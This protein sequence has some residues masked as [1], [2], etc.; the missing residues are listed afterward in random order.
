VRGIAADTGVS[1]N[2]IT[3]YFGG[4]QGLFRAATENDF[5]IRPVLD[6]SLTGLGLRI[7]AHVVNRWEGKLGD[8]PLLTMMR[9]AL[10]DQTAAHHMAEFFVRQG[11]RPLANRLGPDGPERAAA[12]SVFIVGTLVQRYILGSGPAAQANAEQLTAWMG[13]ALQRILTGP[14][15]PAL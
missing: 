12:V 1:P 4:K 8:D 5:D 10:S 13:N 2:L 9:A 7:A 14:A 3:R 6:G 15:M 11:S